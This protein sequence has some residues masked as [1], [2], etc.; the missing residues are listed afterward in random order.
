M[1]NKF[2]ER[3]FLLFGLNY[4]VGFG[5]IVT[6]AGVISK[7]LWG[8]LI[9]VLT[10]FICGAVML[11]FARGGEN[12]GSEVGGSYV[13]GKKAFPKQRWFIFFQG[14]NQFAQ[15]PLFSATTPLFFSG[16]LS[17]LDKEH[18]EIYLAVS[19]VFFLL[20]TIVSALGLKISKWF[21][22]ISAII[23]WITIITGLFIVI[24]LSATQ[25]DFASKLLS[26]DEI[27]IGVIVGSV[28]SFIYA[29]GGLEGLAGLS[30]DVETKRFKKILV[31]I[32][33][34]ILSFYLIFYLIFLGVSFN[35]TTNSFSNLFKLVFG[36]TGVILFAI[37][38]FFNRTTSSISSL[39]Y[40]ARTVV[41]LAE[42]GFLPSSLAI[43]G[44]NN[45]Y[46]N[47]IIFCTIFASISMIIFTLIPYF[48]GIEDKFHAILNAGNIVFL[49]QYLLTIFSIL[50]IGYKYKEFK[51]PIWE[52]ILLYFGMLVI[53]FVILISFIPPMVGEE[54]TLS[55][56][57][58]LPSYAGTMLIGYA[59]WGLWHWISK[60]KQN[61]SKL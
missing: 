46:K 30:A 41:P 35:D 28:L 8:M 58:L 7:G 51:I 21:I 26:K 20:T 59:I 32:F 18:Q 42:D 1:K 9:F 23:K 60:R 47:A 56:A 10:A 17:E 33:I 55:T 13:Y 19:I 25:L 61:K 27:T 45:N 14:W 52:Q 16:L 49:M 29:F 31:L 50:V 2:S 39:V 40:Y 36:I 38:L 34:I 37:G 22:F 3:Q 54:Y 15:V 53:I 57:I 11:A 5:F 12:F 48:L 4:I 24:Y 6:I 44:K 43:K